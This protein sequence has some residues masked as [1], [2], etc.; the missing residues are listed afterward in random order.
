[1]TK[2]ERIRLLQILKK[3]NYFSQK[4]GE[5]ADCEYFLPEESQF[6]WGGNIMPQKER[7]NGICVFM[8]HLIF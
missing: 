6:T 5:I 2:C 8:L 4:V 3:N 7:I 1:M